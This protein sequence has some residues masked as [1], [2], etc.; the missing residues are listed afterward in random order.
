M[1]YQEI[2]Q[3]G[4]TKG[5]VDKE[6]SEYMKLGK[7]KYLDAASRFLKSGKRS[8]QSYSL[9]TKHGRM[10]LKLLARMA[11]AKHNDGRHNYEPKIYAKALKGLGVEYKHS[12]EKKTIES[13]VQSR[14]LKTRYE[15]LT[16]PGQADFR[17]RLIKKFDGKCALTGC[18]VQ[19]AL[20]AAHILPVANDGSDEITNGILL[21]CDVH[22]LFDLGLIHISAKNGQVT[23]NKEVESEYRP[24]LEASVDLSKL[25]GKMLKR[26]EKTLF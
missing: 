4:L 8:S 2:I 21:R 14:R 5:A 15:V 17:K 10:P 23:L 22:R 20:E 9:I 25:D 7:E 18:A 13:A 12:P 16:R 6:I 11:Y 24:Q 26:R 3:A 19:A 1:T